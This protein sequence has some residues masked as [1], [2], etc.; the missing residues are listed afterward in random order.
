MA[1]VSRF[2]DRKQNG[3][4][5]GLGVS[6]EGV[7]FQGGMMRTL[8]EWS[9]C[10]AMSMC[11]MPPMHNETVKMANSMPTIFYHKNNNKMHTKQD[12]H[13]RI[14]ASQGLSTECAAWLTMKFISTILLHYNVVSAGYSG[15]HL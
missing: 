6:A 11:L 13:P 14:G 4:G 5:Q 7:Q 15:A 8:G 9:S 12:H 3:G 1:T 10:S 2:T